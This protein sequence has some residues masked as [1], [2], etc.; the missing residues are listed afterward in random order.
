[1]RRFSADTHIH[2]DPCHGDTPENTARG[3]VNSGIDVFAITDHA[4]SLLKSEE[5]AERYLKVKAEIRKLTKGTSRRILG[6]FGVEMSIVFGGIR[7]HV[8]YI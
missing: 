8:G 4:A 1:M 2:T 3:I 5:P 7:H 6:L